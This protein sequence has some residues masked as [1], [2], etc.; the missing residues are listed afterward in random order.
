MRGREKR[1]GLP[2]VEGIGGGGVVVFE[3]GGVTCAAHGEGE[4]GVD[5]GVEVGEGEGEGFVDGTGGGAGADDGGEGEGDAVG[6][7]E[8]GGGG[9]GVV[10][11]FV[12]GA[13]FFGDAAEEGEELDDDGGGV[14]RGL[15]VGGVAVLGHPVTLNLKAEELDA[16]IG[17]LA[18]Q[19][20]AGMECY[21]SEH[22]AEQSAEYLA[23]AKKYGLVPTGGS[24]Y[25]GKPGCR[26][27]IGTGFGGLNMPDETVGLLKARLARG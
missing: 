4:E 3:G 13:G 25:H 1:E 7:G 18:A 26:L 8:E 20:L 22:S 14:G 21:Y 27:E 16:F 24:D 12:D 23:I 6:G 10:A 15:A 17:S 11:G 2:V 5:D 9:V 19:G